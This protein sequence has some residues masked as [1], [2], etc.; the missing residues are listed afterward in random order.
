MRGRVVADRVQEVSLPDSRRPVDEERVV[1]LSGHLR[2]RERGG[3]REA[4]ASADDE[5]IER[6][7]RLEDELLPKAFSSR[8]VRWEIAAVSMWL[9]YYPLNRSIDVVGNLGQAV[10]EPALEPVIRVIWCM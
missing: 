10:A 8:R 4:I 7:S 6:V 1:S 9:D 2:D 5:T 3:M